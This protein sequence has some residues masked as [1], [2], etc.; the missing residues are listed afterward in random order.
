MRSY[1]RRPDGMNLIKCGLWAIPVLALAAGCDPD[2]PT[3]QWDEDVDHVAVSGGFELIGVHGNAA[4][5]GCHSSS[6]FAL[7]FQ[8]GSEEDCQACH[9]A[10]FPDQHQERGF[11][12]DCAICHSPTR[13]DQGSFDHEVSSGGF[14]L[15]GPHASLTCTRCHEPGSFDP[16]Y[17]PSNA[18][19]CVACH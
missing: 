15:W 13:F 4:C 14:D 17:S 11:P 7:K 19:D 9:I 16:R 2:Y 8:P 18:Q 10:Q 3:S 6:N 1:T 12:T 5:S